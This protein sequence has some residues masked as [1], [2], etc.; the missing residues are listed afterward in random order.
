[1]EEKRWTTPLCEEALGYAG[2]KLLAYAIGE[3]S[4]HQSS[5]N[6]NWNSLDGPTVVI[7]PKMFVSAMLLSGFRNC[8]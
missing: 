8:A 6:A 3:K 1:M 4:P 2:E 5:F 7:M